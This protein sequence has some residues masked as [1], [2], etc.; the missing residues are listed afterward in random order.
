MHPGCDDF[1]FNL[2]SHTYGQWCT[3]N[4]IILRASEMAYEC[5]IDSLLVC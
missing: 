1:C 2:L 5:V 4:A 3:F